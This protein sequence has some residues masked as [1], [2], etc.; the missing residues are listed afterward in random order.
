MAR[1]PPIRS[2]DHPEGIPGLQGRSRDIVNAGNQ[3]LCF[4]CELATCLIAEQG[5][6]G[7]EQPWPCWTWVQ[8]SLVKLWRMI[9][10]IVTVFNQGN[11]GA[12]WVKPTGL[13]HN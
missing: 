11:Y 4:A 8:E 10:V 3:L 6:F 5:Y 7:I 2:A 1:W 13:I 9:G 12:P